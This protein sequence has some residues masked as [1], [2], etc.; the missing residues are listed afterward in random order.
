[1]PTPNLSLASISN[2]M[3]RMRRLRSGV[4]QNAIR[5]LFTFPSDR[6][7]VIFVIV[8]AAYAA[9]VIQWSL[10]FGR[11]GMD[12]VFDDVGYLIDGLQRLN[13]LDSAGFHAFCRTFVQSPPHSPWSTLLALIAFA[14]IG[15]HDWAPYFLNAL[16]VFFLLCLVW[17]IVDQEDTLARVAITSVVLLLQLPFQAILEFRP[18]FAVA[19]FTA[20]F[21][22]LLL[23]MGV[24]EMEK[25]VELRG[26][27]FAG[28]LAGLAYLT[29][30]SFFPH[31]TF[32]EL[33]PVV[34]REGTV[35]LFE[36]KT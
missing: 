36:K 18:D 31:T 4:P 35:F 29:K 13:V 30:P 20:G 32:R 22:V 15:V 10:R 11:L 12:P 17:D 16:L 28:L 7:F 3:S 5:P 6:W 2:F 14:L 21:S 33:P 26:Y 27:F 25:A 9:N 19:L 8:S 34:G 24:Y 23:K 1:M